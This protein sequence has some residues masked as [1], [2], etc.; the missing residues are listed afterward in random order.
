[1]EVNILKILYRTKDNK[2]AFAIAGGENPAMSFKEIKYTNEQ[3][4]AYL[5]TSEEEKRFAYEMEF[6]NYTSMPLFTSL[7]ALCS[8]DRPMVIYAAEDGDCD[9]CL[10]IFLKYGEGKRPNFDTLEDLRTCMDNFDGDIG[11]AA[12]KAEALVNVMFPER[13][14]EFS[15][16]LG[17]MSDLGDNFTWDRYQSHEHLPCASPWTHV[18]MSVKGEKLW[19]LLASQ[20]TTAYSEERVAYYRQRI[21]EGERFG[22]IIYTIPKISNYAIIL[23]GHHRVLASMLEGVFPDCLLISRASYRLGTRD[24]HTVLN[25]HPSWKISRQNP[26]ISD[27]SNEMLERLGK[28]ESSFYIVDPEGEDKHYAYYRSNPEGAGID[29]SGSYTT[30]AKDMI[31]KAL[32]DGTFMEDEE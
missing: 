27:L 20:P 17:I 30:A 2:S 18:Q 15:H 3:V 13:L 14:Y 1:M 7:Y 11:E 29:L 4:K 8:E 22:C 10:S 28:Y 24:N 25:V 5:T 16:G 21:S 6:G 12:V 31:R 9:T 26:G 23:D 32:L 19:S